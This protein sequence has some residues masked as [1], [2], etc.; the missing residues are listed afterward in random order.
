MEYT[1]LDY[2]TSFYRIFTHGLEASEAVKDEPAP[3]ATEVQDLLVLVTKAAEFPSPLVTGGGCRIPVLRL[4]PT[5]EHGAVHG[6]E[7]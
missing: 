1:L 2:K 4:H 7:H 6:A 5:V 3:K